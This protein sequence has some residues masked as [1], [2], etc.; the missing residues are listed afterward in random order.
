MISKQQKRRMY[1]LHYTLKKRGHRVIARSRLVIKKER[2]LS[3][4][5]QKWISELIKFGYGV[6]DDLFT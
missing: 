5:E 6:C 3:E 4:I 1:K 2:T